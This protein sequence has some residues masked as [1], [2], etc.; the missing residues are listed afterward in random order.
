MPYTNTD[1]LSDLAGLDE[2]LATLE[3]HFVG[4]DGPAHIPDTWNRIRQMRSDVRI[5]VDRYRR[6]TVDGATSY[7]YPLNI[8]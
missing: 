4:I 8:G 6:T 5:L 7:A 3:A 2:T 1:A